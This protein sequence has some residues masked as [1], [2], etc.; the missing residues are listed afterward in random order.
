MSSVTSS[1]TTPSTTS[2][3]PDVFAVEQE[4]EEEEKPSECLGILVDDGLTPPFP[5]ENNPQIM[6]QTV[7]TIVYHG[8]QSE[9]AKLRNALRDSQQNDLCT[10]LNAVME[11]LS[12]ILTGGIPRTPEAVSA[13]MKGLAMVMEAFKQSFPGRE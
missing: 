4:E 13:Q 12:S 9:A 3:S 2:S 1:T 10:Q 5:D 7:G 8:P 6:W 11:G